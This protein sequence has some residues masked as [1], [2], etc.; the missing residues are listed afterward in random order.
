VARQRQKATAP[1][2]NRVAIVTPA[3]VK[4]QT[5][6]AIVEP[7]RTPS[8][9]MLTHL[10]EYVTDAERNRRAD[11]AEEMF[12]EIKRRVGNHG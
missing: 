1:A 4:G 6:S 3:E 11:L 10:A 5:G 7:K 9:A 8:N 2:G 12:R